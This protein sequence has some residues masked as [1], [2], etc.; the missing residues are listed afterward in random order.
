[1]P[2]ADAQ[3]ELNEYLT[4]LIDEVAGAERAAVLS[5]AGDNWRR[6][7]G[8]G[9]APMQTQTQTHR[10]GRRAPSFFRFTGTSGPGI[11]RDTRG[12]G[13]QKGEALASARLTV[14]GFLSGH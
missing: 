9:A 3:R 7:A 11:A 14:I 12:H 10:L 1:M 4:R 2:S 6:L 13:I 8:Q 5:T